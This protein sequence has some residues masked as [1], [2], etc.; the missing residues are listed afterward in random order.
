MNFK[1][2]K[3]DYEKG[4]CDYKFLFVMIPAFFQKINEC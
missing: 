3:C 2:Q 4:H 1:I